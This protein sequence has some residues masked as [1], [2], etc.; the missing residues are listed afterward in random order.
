[1]ADRKMMDAIATL[2]RLTTVPPAQ[3][4]TSV[5]AHCDAVIA[6]GDADARAKVAAQY[7]KDNFGS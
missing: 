1:M 4:P 6:D 2:A 7:I 3:D 5:L